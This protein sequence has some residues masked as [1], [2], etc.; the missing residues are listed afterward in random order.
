MPDDLNL[1]MFEL[2][3]KYIQ[4]C[5]TSSYRKY[6]RQKKCLVQNDTFSSFDLTVLG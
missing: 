6:L 2:E 5:T 3:H 1:N 4:I